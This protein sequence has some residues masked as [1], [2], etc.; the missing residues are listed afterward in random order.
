MIDYPS[1]GG[2]WSH[3]TDSAAGIVWSSYH[4]PSRL[5]RSS[6]TTNTDYKSSAWLGAGSWTNAQLPLGP[7]GNK[8]N[9]AVA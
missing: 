6:V 3:G 2:T 4:H 9:Y 7:W 1:V 5:H 8:A